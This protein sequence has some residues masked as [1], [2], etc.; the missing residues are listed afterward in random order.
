[1]FHK[2][3]TSKKNTNEFPTEA[4]QPSKSLDTFDGKPLLPA[5]LL[6]ESLWILALKRRIFGMMGTGM[7]Q[8]SFV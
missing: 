6:G 1:M 8:S 4:N 2:N 7:S 3:V 5:P